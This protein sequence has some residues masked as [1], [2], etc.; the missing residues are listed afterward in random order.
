MS[1]AKSG[2]VY[3]SFNSLYVY[4]VSGVRLLLYSNLE[5]TI[6]LTKGL[7]MNR[8]YDVYEVQCNSYNKHVG[9]SLYGFVKPRTC[10]QPIVKSDRA[11]GPYS[12]TSNVHTSLETLH[13]LYRF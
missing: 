7:Q 8:I 11:W 13:V 6:L 3:V 4:S 5:I 10:E 9:C 1:V 12:H 2:Y